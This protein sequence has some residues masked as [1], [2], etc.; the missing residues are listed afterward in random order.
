MNDLQ[1]RLQAAVGDAYRIEEELGGGGMSRVFLADEERLGRKVVIKVLPPEMSAGVNVERFER[2]IQ[3]AAKLQHPHIVPLLTA[4][5]QDD[6]LYYVMPYIKGESL[7]AKLSREGELPVAEA[8]HIIREVIDALTHAH[9][10]GVVHRDIKPDN[11]LLSGKHALV[12]DFGV[13]KAV[14]S[15]TGESS[16]T[17]LGVALGT[18][19][20]M[21]PEQA[22]ADPHVD[23]RADI[24]AVGTLAYEMLCGRPPFTG[25]NP[26]TIL[27]AHV[28]QTPDP[29]TSH[30]A[31]VPPALNDLVL[32]CLEKKPADRPQRAEDLLPLLQAIS[33]PSGGVTPTGT[34]PVSAVDLQA[35]LRR[36]HPARVGALF[37]FAA[38]GV[39]AV[40]YFLVMELGLPTWVVW[41]AVVLLAIGAPIMLL[42]GH[43]ERKRAVAATTQMRA[44]TPAGVQRHFTWRKA[45][46]GGGLA[47]TGLTVVTGGYWAMRIMGIGP[48][49]TLVAS[50]VLEA[51]DP[52]IVADFENRTADSTLGPSITEALRID[53]GQS[54]IVKLVETSAVEDALRLMERDL[55][56]PLNLD[57]A[58]E[59]A[60][61]E[62]YKAV[63]TGEIAPLGSGFVLSARLVSAS[64]G[65]TLVPLRETAKGDDEII[66]AVDRLSAKLR[67]R[68][69]ESL[70]TIRSGVP[71]ERVTTTSL[72][73]L[74]K[75]SQATYI[76]RLEGGDEQAVA[77]LREAVT[78]DTTFAMAYRRL[79]AYL[80]NVGAP[81]SEQIDA[82]SR[83]Y[84]YRDRLPP[85]ERH[86]ATAYYFTTVD[87]DRS[88]I[89]AAYR[90]ALE[91]DPDEMAALNNLSIELRGVDQNRE[92]ED[93]AMRAARIAPEWQFFGNT[94]A[95]QVAQGKLEEARATLDRFAEQ[96]PESPRVH[97]LRTR[98]AA[99]LKDYDTAE[100]ELDSLAAE[101]R[102]SMVWRWAV[103]DDRAQIAATRG[104]L[105][106][107]E[108]H[109]AEFGRLSQQRGAPGAYIVSVIRSGYLDVLFREDREAAMRKLRNGL[110]QQPLDSISPTDRPYVFLAILYAE[111]GDVAAAKQTMREY[112]ETVDEATRRTNPF[113]HMAAARVAAAE[114]RF[115]DAK[116]SARA[117][118]DEMNN[119]RSGWAT[120][121]RVFEAAGETDSAIVM[122]ERAATTP[123]FFT[124]GQDAFNLARSYKRLGEL[125]EAE[126]NR[127]KAVRYYNEF[128]E[129]WN[130]ADPDLQPVVQEVRERIARLVGE[131]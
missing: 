27:S 32:R 55:S 82:A 127:E 35:L 46:L 93:L 116:R 39:L 129:L 121:A 94:A 64:D 90:A 89:I 128:V 16:L 117:F 96:V 86:L 48:V 73:A 17:S 125:Y 2:E 38:L 63:V 72:E 76:N 29:L 70:K 23:H 61:R 30:R 103:A 102:E 106:D 124:L 118:R 20:Y 77:L 40:V 107:A 3:L 22:A 41:G 49:G 115:D 14:S 51:R 101:E 42:T 88:K 84:E 50:G 99:A 131:T 25:T 110:A 80:G 113:R 109:L 33:T 69:G 123:E 4:G 6:L 37:A 108:R 43:H 31:T 56:S 130:D 45:I 7:R 122:Y 126:G 111:A 24:Y 15:S 65:E 28:M 79:A 58:R 18:P 68:I 52:L 12:T 66:D 120:L 34:A 57:L 74:Q 98:L 53:L 85:L 36:T 62:G 119:A 71:L 92:A 47:F 87:F 100:A 91:I 75:F 59:I 8:V 9:A 95:A 97:W 26:Q 105:A 104:R 1:T 21:A 78:L 60:Q 83:A 10:E 54:S 44:A 19:A 11:V 13:A 112:E 67:E 81:F 5:A 114:G